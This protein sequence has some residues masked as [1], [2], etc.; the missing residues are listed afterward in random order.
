[1]RVL[2]ETEAGLAVQR[3]EV[4]GNRRGGLLGGGETQTRPRG[5]EESGSGL[6]WVS[7][8]PWRMREKPKGSNTSTARPSLPL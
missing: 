1:M 5:G 6:Q 2:T 8:S 3:S 4:E 7:G